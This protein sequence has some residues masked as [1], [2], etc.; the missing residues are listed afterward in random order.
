MYI[1]QGLHRHLQ[2]RPQ[3]TAIRY[4]GRDVSFAQLGERVARLAGA[5]KQLGVASGERVAMLSLNS[6]RY[7]E[8][9]LA[10]P[11][12]DAVLN[13]VNIRWS[14][15]E[16]VYSLDDSETSV[17]I[18]DDT[19]L[20]LGQ[21]VAAEAKTLRTLVYAGDGEAPAG[22]LSY[23]RLIAENA[24]VED[25]RRGGDALL[26][27]FYTGG[28]TGF[29]KG[30]M[31][32]HNNL[33]FSALAIINGGNCSAEERYLHAMPMFHMADYSAMVALLVSGGTHVVLPAFVSSAVLRTIAAEN[34]S[35]I[36]LAPTMIQM[37]LDA[38]AADPALC[39]LDLGCLRKLDYG[40]SPITPALLERARAVFA[41]AGFGQGYGMTELGP[42][43]TFLSA[44][45]HTEEHQRSGRMYSA[46][47]PYSCV[48]I[49]IVDAEDREVPRGSVGEIV[50]KGPN[51]MLGYWNKP[52]A[53]AEALHGGWMHT[54]DGG[55][56]DEDG[57]V[58][59]C[60]RLK[61]MIV[62][63]GENVYSAEVE[64]AIASHPAV[65]QGAVIGI[66]SAKW[67]ES[68][69]AV[70]VLKPGASVTEEEV[71]AHCRE[72]IAGYKLPRSVEFRDSLPLSSVGKVLKAELRAPFWAGHQRGVA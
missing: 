30:V 59:V 70:L 21:K 60:D 36:L 6:Q 48:E 5:L 10:V 55:Y 41:S 13:P 40:A 58:H 47:R 53:T 11:W 71:V 52:E 33:G 50:V 72:R 35:E 39:D 20:A 64:A 15:A 25:A 16:I 31:L 66:P 17:L 57:F 34:V 46:G 12:A 27:I 29:P 9:Y 54:G 3:A 65:A 42:V 61:D 37:L 51:V 68:V 49:R 28:T 69:H 38:R 26:G 8:Y 4:Q 43:A 2:Q 32:S 1:T 14:A 44:E 7:I 56:M 23:E 67:G 45:F 22:M 18:V 62:S 24:P 19:F 63:G